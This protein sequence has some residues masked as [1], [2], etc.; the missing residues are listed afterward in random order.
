M[1]VEE[2]LRV[3]IGSAPDWSTYPD[4]RRILVVAHTVTTLTRLLD[5][6][7][8]FDSD[9]RIQLVFTRAR[10]SNFREGVTEFLHDIGAVVAPWE[11]AMEEEFDLAIA[12]SY[13]DDLH[14]IN[15]PLVV[16]SHGAGFNKLGKTENGKRKA[17]TVFGLGPATLLRDGT[18]VPGTLVLSHPEQLGRLR[19]SCPEA[20]EAALIAGDPSHD[21][22]LAG[23]PWRDRY[24]DHLET[25]HRKLVVVSSTW[26][27]GSLLGSRPELLN[28]LLAELPVDE[29][30]V[31]LA[32][33][34]NTWHG[35]GHHQVRSWLAEA[36]RA[37]LRVLPPRQ[38]WQAALVAADHVIG[39]HGSVTAYGASLGTHTML[40]AFPDTEMDPFSPIARF[41]RSA[42]RLRADL[43]LLP[44]IL[45]D[46]ADHKPDR[47]AAFTD[48]LNSEPGGSGRILRETFY[49]LLDLPEPEHPVRTL[50]A[51]VPIPYRRGW[52]DT[53]DH[54]PLWSTVQ[55]EGSRLRVRRHPAESV[56]KER[57]FLDRPHL[58][59]HTDETQARWSEAACLL[60]CGPDSESPGGGASWALLRARLSDHPRAHLAVAA[61]GPDCLLV[62][63]D[64][65]RIRLVADDPGHRHDPTAAASAYWHLWVEGEAPEGSLLVLLGEHES[66]FTVRASNEE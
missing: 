38:G 54:A 33:H 10:T 34:P 17:E 64:G 44:Q 41:G 58:V 16:F 29:Y 19:L 23:L 28:R 63:R 9:P 8:L 22:I 20:V 12:A 45:A 24:R 2:R 65:T 60:L 5:V 18:L 26:G 37:G 35:H 62:D 52:P 36:E 49:R 14:L 42:T 6:L 21:R 51:D 11:Q 30:R 27:P 4:A 57:L 47:F 48:R 32:L 40:G 13:G 61:D 31:A 55:E 1:S 59:T 56:T 25:G 15:A 3:P 53:T 43:P 39:D 66:S 7:P 50:P 46:A